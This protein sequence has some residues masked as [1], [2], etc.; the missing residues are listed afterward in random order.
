MVVDL[1][2]CLDDFSVNCTN[3]CVYIPRSPSFDVGGWCSMFTF[4]DSGD[5]K[6]LVEYEA[7]GFMVS[8]DQD[9]DSGG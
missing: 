6:A 5:T 1:F 7:K 2:D 4:L 9:F 3:G 8:I